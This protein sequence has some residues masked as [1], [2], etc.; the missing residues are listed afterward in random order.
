MKKKVIIFLSG[1]MFTTLVNAQEF[2]WS[3]QSMGEPG[4]GS[5][6]GQDVVC[7][8]E[9]NTIVT[10]IFQNTVYFGDS[11]VSG[12]FGIMYVVKYDQQGNTSWVRQI[13]GNSNNRSYGIAVDNEQNLYVC[14][15]YTHTNDFTV[16]DFGTMQAT[17]N[18]SLSTFIAK[19][20]KDGNWEWVNTILA[21]DP[22]GQQICSPDEVLVTPGGDIFLAGSL[23]TSV[24]IE[25]SLYNSEN[26]SADAY[27][28]ARF[29][30][31]GD[32]VWFKSNKG[33]F[34]EIEMAL[35]SDDKLY[36][37]GTAHNT[38]H[39]FG[40]SITGPGS[41]DVLFGVLNPDGTLDWWQTAGH[42][43]FNEHSKG[44]A[45]DQ[46]NNI[47]LAFQNSFF[48]KIG[49]LQVDFNGVADQYLFKLDYQGNFQW[50]Q[51]LYAG[52]VNG[53]NGIRILD[54]LTSPTGLTFVTGLMES[55]SFFGNPLF[56][57]DT[58]GGFGYKECYLA[59]YTQDGSYIDVADFVFGEGLDVGEFVPS[60][61]VFDHN[62]EIAITGTFRETIEVGDHT[63]ESGSLNQMF[64]MKAIPSALFDLS[65]GVVLRQ[66]DELDMVLFP[67]PARNVLHFKT[68]NTGICEYH[69][70]D[71]YGRIIRSGT[72]SNARASIDVSGLESGTYYIRIISRDWVG[73]KAFLKLS[74][75]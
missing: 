29:S 8:S 40:D 57:T 37:S 53:V 15:R 10:G 18:H 51:P 11:V 56:F 23:N 21:G 69:L 59:A 41:E 47:Y 55:P 50:A 75:S 44:I 6:E 46:D 38:I 2:R 7:D 9:G 71:S 58:V 17:G 42:P 25:D 20:D 30:S 66:Q 63:L 3:T 54:I 1:I 67:N 48:V 49:D 26:G 36:F 52:S 72:M 31:A 34:D 45:L 73:V 74:G 19:I 5:A 27:Y 16:L 12:N 70:A 24:T 28:F 13:N 33:Y 22:V 68:K 62:Q 39:F 35:S 14:G 32:L 4:I 60:H 43:S 61:M 64:V 65:S